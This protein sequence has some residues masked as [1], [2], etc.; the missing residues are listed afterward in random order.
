MTN[1]IEIRE[2]PDDFLAATQALR[3]A[4]VDLVTLFPELSRLPNADSRAMAELADQDNWLSPDPGFNAGWGTEPIAV[5]HQLGAFQLDMAMDCAMAIVRLME[6]LDPGFTW[7]PAALLR[8]VMEGA[9]RSFWLSQKD[10]GTGERLRRA[11]NELLDD[12]SFKERNGA[13]TLAT[14]SAARIAEI[15]SAAQ[16]L[17]FDVE[18]LYLAPSRPS[19]TAVIANMFESISHGDDAKLFML[20]SSGFVHAVPTA[21]FG[22]ASE[23]PTDAKSPFGGNAAVSLTDRS[24]NL[25]LA[26]AIEPIALAGHV[27]LEFNNWDVPDWSSTA[28]EGL[29]AVRETLG[30]YKQPGT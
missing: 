27:R 5:A 14:L 21:L 30:K 17:G 9:A 16:L 7:S 24:A 6:S 2:S 11:V 12:Y 8:P 20:Y 29:A 10:I 3:T 13:G 25:L 18:K 22:Y 19:A 26:G 1:G 4:V 28:V 15:R 23:I